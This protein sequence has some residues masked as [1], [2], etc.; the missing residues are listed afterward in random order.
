MDIARTARPGPAAAAKKF[1]AT[2]APK[3]D[4][5]KASQDPKDG[6]SIGEYNGARDGAYAFTTLA[7]T[8]AAPAGE[9]FG[10]S[11]YVE[12]LAFGAGAI[13][14]A[15]GV[16]EAATA[17]T[18]RGKLT[19]SIRAFAGLTNMVKPFAGNYSGALTAAGLMAI[20]VSYGL[21]QPGTI[22]KVAG[23]EFGSMVK[24]I[25]TPSKWSPNTEANKQA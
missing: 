4:G 9:I 10:A 2:T 23:G 25:F 20:G 6:V 14:T 3:Q 16:Q 24:D 8:L 15:A 19:G 7:T 1:E 11:P 5:E 17:G 13:M 18:T 12:G 21:N 22:A